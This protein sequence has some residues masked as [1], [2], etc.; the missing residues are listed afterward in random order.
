MH[1]GTVR[2]VCFIQ[3]GGAGG[4][5][6]LLLSGGAGDCKICVTDV[7]TNTPFMALSGHTGGHLFFCLETYNFF[8]EL[9]L[10]IFEK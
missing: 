2:D 8:L 4:G 5:S 1:D 7:V 10:N 3:D 9:Y 6:P